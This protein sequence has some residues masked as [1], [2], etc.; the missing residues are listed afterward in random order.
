DKNKGL[1]LDSIIK[2]KSLD[3]ISGEEALDSIRETVLNRNYKEIKAPKGLNANLRD[4]QLI[5]YEWLNS[6]SD[7]GFGCILADEMGLGKTIQ[8]IAFLLSRKKSK[9]LVI[10]PTSLIYNWRAEFEN[11]APN[12]KIGIVHGS[13]SEREKVLENKNDYDVI[14]TTYGTLRNDF[15]KYN[16]TIFDYCIIDE[17]QNIKNNASQ[18]TKIVKTINANCKIALSGTPIENNLTELWSIFDFIMPKFLYNEEKFKHKFIN[19]GGKNIEDLKTLIKPFILRRLK[20]DVL[21]ELPNKI[22]KKYFV[23]MPMAQKQVYKAYMKEVKAKMK[24]GKDDKLTIFSY[25][26]KL[27]QLCLDPSIVSEEYCGG[28]GK[29]NATMDILNTAIEGNKKILIFSQFTTVLKKIE[30]EIKKVGIE[31]LYLDGSTKSKNRLN[32]V[33]E[34]NENENIKVFLISL[35]AGGT[36]LNLTSA[37]LVI[38]FD[39]WWNPAIEDQASDR[40]H[41][42]GQK[43]VVEVIKLI[44]QDTIEEKIIKMQDEKKELI[45]NVMNGEVMDGKVLNRLSDE[46]I[47]EL[48]N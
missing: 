28:S 4:Y 25:L 21:L 29:I 9:S 33:N 40:A 34:F 2:K 18:S 19:S 43:R 10:T 16:E 6:I 32:L 15:E 8:T 47:L 14:L 26:T 12:M 37:N 30:E 48:F 5:G 17:A 22:E 36:G 13:K 23:E 35:K 1:Y 3:F 39:P 24:S 27:R 42:M 41:R 20:E 11:F 44:S 45:N 38:H 31:Y 46:E 7:M